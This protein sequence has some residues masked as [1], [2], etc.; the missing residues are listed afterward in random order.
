MTTEHKSNVLMGRYEMGKMLGQGT[1]AKVY[2]ARNTETSESVAIKAIDKEKVM[3]VG[4]MDQI[5]REVS[6]MKMV[7]H[8]NIVQLY[9]VMAT[10]T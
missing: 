9:E 1:F 3:K 5:K 10:K 2:H 7:R 4:L 6:V 8:P